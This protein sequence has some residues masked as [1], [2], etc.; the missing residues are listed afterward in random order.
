MAADIAPGILR[1]HY[2]FHYWLQH[3]QA[4][5][6]SLVVE[7]QERKAAGLEKLE[8]DIRG[9]DANPRVLEFTTQNIENAGLDEHI[10]LAHKPIDQFGKPTADMACY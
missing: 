7:A 2:G 9:Y 4:L 8:L 3:D 1:G 10:R 6:D 5:W